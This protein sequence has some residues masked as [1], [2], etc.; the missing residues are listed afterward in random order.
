MKYVLT[1]AVIGMGV[2][3]AAPASAQGVYIGPGGVGVDT[4]VRRHDEYRRDR[5]R[6]EDYGERRF[7]EGRSV[8]R[9]GERFRDR[10]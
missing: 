1:A 7:D 6:D 4:G 9:D 5:Y 3:A 8:Y 2:I 10:D